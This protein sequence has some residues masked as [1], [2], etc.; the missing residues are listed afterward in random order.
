MEGGPTRLV[1]T[2]EDGRFVFDALPAGRYTLSATK[3]GYVEAFHGSRRSGRGPGVAVAVPEGQRVDVALTIVRGAVI[4]GTVTDPYGR[5]A[6]SVS[7]AIV[8]AGSPGARSATVRVVTDD[9]GVYRAFGLTPGEYLVVALP[10]LGAGAGGRGA[11]ANIVSVTEAEVRWARAIGAGAS[12][13]A[14]TPPPG[15]AVAYAPIFYPGTADAASAKTV[16]VDAGEERSDVGFALQAVPTARIDGT[17]LDP[18]GGPRTT[19]TVWLYPRRQ[20]GRSPADALISSGAVTAPR[21]TASAAGFALPGVAPGDYTIVAWS[22][23][24]G[25]GAARPAAGQTPDTTTLWSVGDLT[26]DGDMTG[27]VLQLAPGVRL[28][29]TIAFEHTVLTPPTDMSAIEVSLNAIGSYLGTASTSRPRVEPNG[30]FAFSGI[31]P[32]SYTLDARPPSAATGARWTLKSAVLNDRDLAD[33]AF[34]LQAGVDDLTGL[35]VT[36]T[37]R[38]ASISGRLV[39]P[40]G[41]PV[42]RYSIVVATTDRSLWLPNAR[43]I[44]AVQPATDGSFTVSGLPA[45]EYAIAA[46][47]DVEAADLADPAFLEQLL[48]A[49]FKVTLADGEQKRQDLRVG[50]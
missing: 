14:T 5:P 42:T 45:G 23:S 41:Q 19:G 9:R 33:G 1:G 17:L 37:D 31:V 2:G 46:A 18:G 20:T 11:P 3:P 16:S 26:V 39:D 32:W 7:M 24:S 30:D 4:A 38:A 22:G 25:R 44:R 43:R 36:F 15:R 6:P 8:H 34:E 13:R 40:G 21:A 29:G 12:E 47:E 28:S 48:A 35:V 27:L 49:A 50:G 10:L